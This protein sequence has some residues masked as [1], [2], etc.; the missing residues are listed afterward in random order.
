[1]GAGSELT[2]FAIEVTAFACVSLRLKSVFT[3]VSVCARCGMP[4]VFD[5]APFH[6]RPSRHAA[7]PR[8]IAYRAA[9]RSAFCAPAAPDP[10]A[11]ATHV[12][13]CLFHR[14]Y[15]RHMPFLSSVS[16]SLFCPTVCHTSIPARPRPIAVT[17]RPTTDPF[18]PAGR[19]SVASLYQPIQLVGRP[20]NP[21][22]TTTSP[23]TRPA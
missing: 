7:L 11:G 4:N 8:P 12:R 10:D 9:S 20:F 19:T 21:T 15:Q 1:M 17:A 22:T 3:C 2:K 16:L 14:Q 23:S 13:H 18:V 6:T 5:K